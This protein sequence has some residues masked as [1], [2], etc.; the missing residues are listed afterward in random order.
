M[1]VARLFPHC[2]LTVGKSEIGKDWPFAGTGES[3][4]MMGA[5]VVEKDVD[6]IHVDTNY[7]I[8]TTPAFMKNASF[9]EVFTGVGKMVDE[10]LKLAKL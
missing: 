3:L 2:E 10:V 1:V 9:Y 8:V 5:N 4:K 7:K 6:E